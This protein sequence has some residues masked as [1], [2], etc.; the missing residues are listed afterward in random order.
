MVLKKKKEHGSEWEEVTGDNSMVISFV[1]CVHCKYYLGD[2]TTEDEMYGAEK[3]V[4]G[5]D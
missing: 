3:C 1:I 4:R 2:Q 5:L